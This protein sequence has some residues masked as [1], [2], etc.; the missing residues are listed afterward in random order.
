MLGL[1]LIITKKNAIAI[2]FS[3]YV[4]LTIET[5]NKL[6]LPFTT[7]HFGKPVLYVNVNYNTNAKTLIIIKHSS[8]LAITHHLSIVIPADTRSLL[9]TIVCGHTIKTNFSSKIATEIAIK[10]NP[11]RQVTIAT[12]LRKLNSLVTTAQ[13]FEQ[14]LLRF[15]EV[16]PIVKRP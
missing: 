15:A 14:V 16:L 12:E 13:D 4:K 11:D 5:Y 7:A 6:N 3:V 8:T 10:I 1:F 9:K 2:G